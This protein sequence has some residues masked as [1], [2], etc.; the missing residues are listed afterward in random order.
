MHLKRAGMV[1]RL[2][3][4]QPY[5]V[6]LMRVYMM[7]SV[8]IQKSI[9][10]ALLHHN[11]CK[12]GYALTTFKAWKRTDLSSGCQKTI[13]FSCF[14]A[15][16]VDNRWPMAILVIDDREA[17]AARQ[18]WEALRVTDPFVLSIPCWKAKV[19]PQLP[20]ELP[21]KI[22]RSEM[23]NREKFQQQIQERDRMAIRTIEA[24]KAPARMFV[25]GGISSKTD[26]VELLGALNNLKPEQA[27][28]VDMELK[29]WVKSDGTPMDKPEIVFANSLRRR[30]EMAGLPITAYMSGKAQVTVRRLTAMEIKERQAGKGKRKK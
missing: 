22:S 27:A 24:S 10:M 9:H 15:V 2:V 16:T 3:R 25:R 14:L 11:A 7:C 8:T 30:F 12:Y 6:V 21:N 26:Y 20:P 1:S 19:L 28:I 29:D 5:H 23:V 18:A 13:D 4:I 17:M